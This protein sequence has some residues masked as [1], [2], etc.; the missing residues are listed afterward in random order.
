MIVLEGG[1][2]GLADVR[3][4]RWPRH[5]ARLEA[6]HLDRE[7]ASGAS[8]ESSPLLAVH[9]QRIVDPAACSALAGSVRRVIERTGRKRPA[10]SAQVP[11]SA[12]PCRP[13]P[14][15]CGRLPTA[16]TSLVLSEPGVSPR[17]GRYSATEPVR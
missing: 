11:I 7:L 10:L 12:S 9:A 1:S 4:G 13:S 14:A 15:I 16:S 8:P 17:S 5:K 6:D 3:P 2:V